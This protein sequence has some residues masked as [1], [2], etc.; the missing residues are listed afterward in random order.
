MRIRGVGGDATMWRFKSCP[1]CGGD[2]FIDRDMSG[3]YE[4]CLQCGYIHDMETIVEVK[5]QPRMQ[6]MKK[7]EPVLAGHQR[8]R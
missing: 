7:R 6:Q 5:E 8:R 4:Q 1:K 3:W 2:V